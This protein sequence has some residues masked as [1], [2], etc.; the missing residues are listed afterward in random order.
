MIY[1]EDFNLIDEQTLKELNLKIDEVIN[2]KNRVKINYELL[3]K[4]LGSISINSRHMRINNTKVQYPI[5]KSE[6]IGTTLDFFKSID[7]RI[8]DEAINI[9]LKKNDKIKLN[10]YNIRKVNDFRSKNE[11]NMRLYEK[12]AGVRSLNGKATIY[13]PTNFEFKKEDVKLLEKKDIVTI[14]DLYTIVHEISHIFDLDLT[15]DI[16]NKN[17][18]EKVK[19]GTRELLG[20]STAIAFEWML[21][22][23]LLKNT[24]YPKDEIR[25][26]MK[27]RI[28]SSLIET[29]ISYVKL[30]LARE[31]EKN[32]MISKEYIENFVKD[33]NINP[34]F[35]KNMIKTV[36]NDRISVAFSKRY[37]LSKIISPMIV[38]TIR[39]NGNDALIK[40]LQESKDDNFHGAMEALGIELNNKG[41][42]KLIINMKQKE[43]SLGGIER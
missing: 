17:T 14:D 24:E 34:G 2:E 12:E 21:T 1:F 11:S 8:Y 36:I 7:E 40:Y 37:A 22:D 25:D 4:V 23:Y 38:E 16:A 39:K 42:E 13:I 6:M 15:P 3:E 31:K 29:N 26:I 43:A 41:I 35:A 19:K 33:K 20:E 32:G 5:K 27:R 28:N 9:I 30:L 10:I 18:S